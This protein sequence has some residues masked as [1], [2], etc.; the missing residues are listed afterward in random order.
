MT[1][2]IIKVKSDPARFRRTKV[3]VHEIISISKD[4]STC[5]DVIRK[6]PKLTTSDLRAAYAYYFFNKEE[7]DQN[8][9]KESVK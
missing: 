5:A 9:K 1:N 7:V 8:I 3:F 2:R 6:F 4:V